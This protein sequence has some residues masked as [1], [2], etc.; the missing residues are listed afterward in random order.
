MAGSALEHGEDR[1]AFHEETRGIEKAT[2][3]A[4]NSAMT[5][6]KFSAM[7]VDTACM[8]MRANPNQ[9][10]RRFEFV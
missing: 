6:F 1:N 2:R 8:V 5:S 7:K 10:C 9:Y 3:M 4:G